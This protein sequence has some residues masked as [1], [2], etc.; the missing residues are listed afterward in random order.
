MFWIFWMFRL[1]E[2]INTKINYSR[3]KYSMWDN[4][5][6]NANK[7]LMGTSG[8]VYAIG[9]FRTWAIPSKSWRCFGT[10]QQYVIKCINWS[11]QCMLVKRKSR[12]LSYS[13]FIYIYYLFWNSLQISIS[14]VTWNQKFI[15]DIHKKR[16]KL[17][18]AAVN[19]SEWRNG[20]R[21]TI[22]DVIMPVLWVVA[23]FILTVSIKVFGVVR[24]VLATT[25]LES[26]VQINGIDFPDF[27]VLAALYYFICT[28]NSVFTWPIYIFIYAK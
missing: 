10:K 3:W 9:C 12:L 4:E 11:V 22:D 19:R 27:P 14:I 28:S 21:Q 18:L 24:M 7:L 13:F 1:Q 23:F 8:Y 2:I 15:N 6:F 25:A 17:C 5:A 20:R 26:V 16:H